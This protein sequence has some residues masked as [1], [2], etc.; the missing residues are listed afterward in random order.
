M[1]SASDASA[2]RAS[3]SF[4]CTRETDHLPSLD[5]D[6]NRLFLYGRYLE[7]A[8][9]PKDFDVVARYYRI[10]AAYGHYKAN[11][12]LQLLISE[13]LASSPDPERETIDLAEQLIKA[14]I[15]GG[16]YDM[17]HY[18]ELGY[19]VKQDAE[20]ARRY[21]RKAA[22]LGNPEA[23][24]YIGDLL[25]PRDMAPDISRQ[26]L[27][28]AIDQGYGKAG[29]Y[30]GIDLST[31]KLYAEAVQSFQKGVAAG[32]AQSA[33]FL[34]NGFVTPS[35]SERLYYLSLPMDRERSNRYKV[36]RQFLDTNEGRNPKIPDIDKIV[37]LPPAKLPP[38]DGTFQ[39]EKEQAAVVAPEKPSDELIDRMAKAKHLDPETGLPLP[40]GSSKS[41]EAT[42]PS[43][44]VP[45]ANIAGRVPIGTVAFSGDVCPEDG[46]WCANL[47]NRQ[48]NGAE[49]R[50]AKGETL[51]TLIV[52][53]PR[54]SSLLGRWRERREYPE[55][56]VWQLTAYPEQA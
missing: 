56:V 38:W 39:W 41:S 55:R 54:P 21:F 51:P 29:S 33:S 6:S 52:Q 28:C 8:D 16:Y 46:V 53:A 40:N 1:S 48:P 23:Q 12:N 7:K 43:S 20:K 15:P 3:L 24:Y 18:L 17:G 27:Q 13:G 26:M 2:V 9:G 47:A 49:R 34:E 30:L 19:G 37:P 35:S 36:I 10:A 31:K 22:D 42:E 14:G 32:S 4:S 45:A 50:F 11:H 44:K 5:P 25:S